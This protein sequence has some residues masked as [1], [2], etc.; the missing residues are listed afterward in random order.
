MEVDCYQDES[1]AVTMQEDFKRHVRTQMYHICQ[2]AGMAEQWLEDLPTTRRGGSVAFLLLLL[3]NLTNLVISFNS[4]LDYVS[5][6]MQLSLFPR[7]LT[8]RLVGDLYAEIQFPPILRL[9]SLRMFCADSLET[10]MWKICPGIS[11]L[12]DLEVTDCEMGE[13]DILPLLE[14]CSE[15]RKFTFWWDQPWSDEDVL[16]EEL[17]YGID[18]APWIIN[19]LQRSKATLEVLDLSGRQPIRH[20]T[21]SLG[22]LTNFDR[23]HT[24][25]VP[26]AMVINP[27]SSFSGGRTLH[28]L[29]ESLKTLHLIVGYV[30]RELILPSEVL[31]CVRCKSWGPALKALT[32]TWQLMT[33]FHEEVSEI[34]TM[35]EYQLF[36][37][38]CEGRGIVFRFET[39]GNGHSAV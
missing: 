16:S 14:A 34:C 24:L 10:Q 6:A 7:L 2:S 3:P 32:I 8:L 18:V 19:G 15:L 4:S 37:D 25:R 36:K 13:E 30:S 11:F 5:T 26:A 31:D 17:D 29:P 38:A 33:I 23:L 20:D 28:M 35:A 27:D 9:D 12:H 22:N 21:M 39:L 1:R